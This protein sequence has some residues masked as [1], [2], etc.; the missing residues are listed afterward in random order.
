MEKKRLAIKLI[1][2][3]AGSTTGTAEKLFLVYQNG[4]KDNI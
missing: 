3:N 2:F 1:C 4:E